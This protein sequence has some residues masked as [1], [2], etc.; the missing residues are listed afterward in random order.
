MKKVIL[1][2]AFVAA[3][4][5]FGNAYAAKPVK[6]EAKTEQTAAKKVVP[7][8][9]SIKAPVKK[10]TCKK[11]CFKKASPTKGAKPAKK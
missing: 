4:M 11:A 10:C 8:K 1:S 3:L 9:K 7:A 6:K 5:C 2:V